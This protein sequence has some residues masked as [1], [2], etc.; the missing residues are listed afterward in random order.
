MRMDKRV[1][2]TIRGLHAEDGA[3][4]IPLETVT[5][6]EY[7]K[8]NNNHYLFYQEKQESMES[9]SKCR[10]KFGPRLVELNRQ[11]AVET[12]MVFEEGRKHMSHYS[13]PYGELLL[14][15]DTKRV[16][17]EEQEDSVRATIEYSLEINGEHQSDSRIELLVRKS[18]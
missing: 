10:I 11:G 17:L 4:G 15:I 8:K 1:E 5:Q 2:L 16:S 18:I 7:F 6:A 13:M 9:P 3:D 14:G 12:R